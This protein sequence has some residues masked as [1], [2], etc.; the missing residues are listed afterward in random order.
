MS[1]SCLFRKR[2][3]KNPQ[4]TKKHHLFFLIQKEEEK[5]DETRVNSGRKGNGADSTVGSADCPADPTFMWLGRVFL[6]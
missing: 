2:Q 5:R 6:L 1:T 4:K 3:K